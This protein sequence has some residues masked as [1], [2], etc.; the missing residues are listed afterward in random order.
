LFVNPLS[1]LACTN[2][3]EVRVSGFQVLRVKGL[4]ILGLPCTNAEEVRVSG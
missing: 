3:E 4:K 2:A 1:S